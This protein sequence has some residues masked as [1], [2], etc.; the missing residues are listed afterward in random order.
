MNTREARELG[1]RMATLIARDRIEPAYEALAPVLAGRAGFALLRHIGGAV[2][3]GAPPAAGPRYARRVHRFLERIAAGRT[4]GGWVVMASA[5]ERR[6]D[7]DLEG[8]LAHTR[9]YVALV[10]VWGGGF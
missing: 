10:D 7:R 4:M 3:A 8:T 2:G 6:L 1:Q 9:R 5:L